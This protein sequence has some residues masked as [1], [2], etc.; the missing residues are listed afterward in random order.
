MYNVEVEEVSAKCALN[1]E[2]VMTK[3]G[4]I[5]IER[6]EATNNQRLSTGGSSK[7]KSK[8][9]NNAFKLSTNSVANKVKE[10][11]NGLN[12]NCSGKCN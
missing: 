6:E 10:K 12:S 1:V 7:S 2:S 9:K 11:I 5:L 4:K 3:I 8:N